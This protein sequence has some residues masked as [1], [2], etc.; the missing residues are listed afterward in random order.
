[1]API[2]L[3]DDTDVSAW[4]A[5]QNITIRLIRA[6][7]AACHAVPMLNATFDDDNMS[8]RLNPEVNLGLAV[9]TEHGLYVPVIK[10]AGALTDKQLREKIDLYKEQARQKSLPQSDL[11]G[12]TITLSNFG[13]LAGRYG[14]PII[15]PPMIAIVGVGKARDAV[16]AA[17]G[18]PAV[19]RII[20][21]SITIDHRAATGG[22]AARF[23]KTMLDELA[24]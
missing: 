1:V 17:A 3:S 11:H 18:K 4:D 24:K 22:D 19:H 23:L 12:A 5:Q 7:V 2:T 16:V 15:V 20:P 13:S 8:I 21:L 9:D 14:S 10:N 6:V